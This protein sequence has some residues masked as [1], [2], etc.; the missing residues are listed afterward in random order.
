[1]KSVN[2]TPTH[3]ACTDAHSVSAH[4]PLHSA[5]TFHHANTRG[6]RAHSSGLHALVSQKQLS[7]RSLP[8]LTLTTSTSSLSPTSPI[9]Q[10]FSPSHPRI[11]SCPIS[12]KKGTSA[13]TQ[14]TLQVSRW[15]SNGTCVRDDTSVQILH[16]L[17][18]FISGTGQANESLQD[19]T[20]FASMLNDI[21]NWESQKVQNTSL[22]R[23]NE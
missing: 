17:Q 11:Y 19:R 22:A 4:T 3:T 10:S 15:T 8:H 6:S 2:S 7:S 23:A 18:E 12:H 16:T 20:T 1:M 13:K 14:T 9:F 21:P 5:I